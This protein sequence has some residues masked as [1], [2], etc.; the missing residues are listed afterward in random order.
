MV[1]KKINRLTRQYDYS[2][3]PHNL[4][5]EALKY[6]LQNYNTSFTPLS[7]PEFILDT[8]SIILKVNTFQFDNKYYKQI[9]GTAMGTKMVPT[10]ATLV[11][12]YLER[13]PYN[14]YEEIYG[15]VET[16]LFNKL[17]KKILG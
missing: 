11:M 7:L 1:L 6:W 13:C 16:E 12:G 17:F 5:M 14:C 3:I 4:G 15:T 10:Y 2:S 9:Q 8:I